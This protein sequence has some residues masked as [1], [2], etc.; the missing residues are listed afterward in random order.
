MNEH[1][2]PDN[3]TV[4]LYNSDKIDFACVSI[5]LYNEQPTTNHKH[6][7]L[8]P[9]SLYPYTLIPNPHPVGQSHIRW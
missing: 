8:S 7:L 1:G 9:F 2:T 3:L 5:A 6:F 4:S